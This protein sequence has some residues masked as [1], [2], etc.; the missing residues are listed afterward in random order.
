M[1]LRE[2]PAINA[3]L[4]LPGCRSL[5]MPGKTPEVM[6]GGGVHGYA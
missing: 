6:E 1:M 4:V 5:A 2:E 3:A